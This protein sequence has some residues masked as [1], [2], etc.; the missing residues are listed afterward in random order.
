M[1]YIRGIMPDDDADQ[2][3]AVYYFPQYHPD[4]RNDEWHGE[5]WTEWEHVKRAEPRFVGHD[6]PKRPKWGYLD[7]SNPQVMDWKIQAAV[8]HGVS[9]FLFDW[10]WY[11]DEPFLHRALEEGFL[12]TNDGRMEFALMWANH[13]WR[14]L[15]PTRRSTVKDAEGQEDIPVL[16]DGAVSRESFDELVDY[17]LDRYFDHPAYWTVDGEPYFSVFEVNTLLE[18]LGSVEATAEA[19]DQFRSR[20]RDAGFPGLHLNAI[21][22]D[23]SVLDLEGNIQNPNELLDELGFDSVATYN[24]HTFLEFDEFPTVDYEDCIEEASAAWPDLEEAFDLPYYP[25]VTMGWDSSPRTAQTQKFDNLGYPFTPVVD[26]NTPEA[27]EEALERVEA[28]I[29]DQ[30]REKPVII[31]AWNEWT[32]GS[33]LEPDEQ[34]GMAYLEAVD[35]AF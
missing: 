6:Q 9:T 18:G 31:N 12:P 33:Y 2:E 19:L 23:M 5:G 26:G 30:D 28:F 21:V 10:Y 1:E 22:R 27:F 35:D 14:D 11:D 29:D 13:D 16:A 20:T 32:E 3:V 4:A 17:V 25:D 15:Y 24:W 7:E 34:Y 8:D